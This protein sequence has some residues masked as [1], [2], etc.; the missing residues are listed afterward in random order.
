METKCTQKCI[1]G[2][3][4]KLG[5][6]GAFDVDPMCRSGGLALLWREDGKVEIQNFS[7]RHINATITMEGGKPWKLT[8]F[9]GHPDWTKRHDALALLS[10]LKHYQ[11][12]PWLCLGDFNEILDQSEKVGVSLRHDVQMA[13]FRTT[14]EECN[15]S[16][17]GFMGSKFT[18]MNCRTDMTFTKER[19]DRAVAS[20]NWCEIYTQAEVHVMVTCSSDHKPLILKIND[21]Q[22]ERL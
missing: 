9:Y 16:D 22:E 8:G 18:W 20:K 19:L 1:E 14:L 13:Q 17:L 7:R 10:H 2:L 5:F 6:V 12:I 11:P 15:L 3:H 21:K 4:V